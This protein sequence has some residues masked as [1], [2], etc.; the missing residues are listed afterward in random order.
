MEYQLSPVRKFLNR[1]KRTAYEK[2]GAKCARCGNPFDFEQMEADHI[3]LWSP[4]VEP[5]RRTARCSVGTVT[6][7]K[8]TAKAFLSLL[9]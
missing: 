8:A 9:C 7:R 6:G 3:V 1:D 2:Q 4:A 5:L